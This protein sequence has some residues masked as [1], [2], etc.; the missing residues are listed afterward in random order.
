M[1]ELYIGGVGLARGYINQ[2]ELTRRSFIDNPFY[3]PHQPGHSSRLYKTGD[4]VRWLPDG[5][6]EYLGRTD[7]QIKLRGL[8]IELTEIEN[9]LLQVAGVSEGTVIA[10]KMDNGDSRLLAYIVPQDKSLLQG[11]T[12]VVARGDYLD[13]LRQAL[14]HQLLDYM[15]PDVFVL[16]SE[17]PLSANG[18]LDRKALPVPDMSS[19]Q[20]T[21]V[22]PET[23][24]ERVIHDIW[25][26]H[27]GLNEISI[28]DNFFQLGGHSILVINML[29]S[30]RNKGI[31]LE[32]R[33]I[34]SYPTIYKLSC[35][36]D[37]RVVLKDNSFVTPENLICPGVERI[38]PQMLPLVALE[39]TEI[40]EIVKQVPGGL[41][42]VQD[43]YPLGPLQSG[44]LYHYRLTP[45]SDPYLIPAE[46]TINGNAQLE[47]FLQA[48]Q[49]VMER[50]DTLRT[51]I[52]WEGTSTPVQVVCKQVDLS[53]ERIELDKQRPPFERLFTAANAHTPVIEIN[54]GP[55]IKIFAGAERSS[56][57]YKVLI[58]FHHIVFDHVGLEII[59]GE[60]AAYFNQQQEALTKP[61]QYREFIATLAN[62]ST[63]QESLDFFRE[64]LA[65]IEE[66]T[67]PFGLM[68]VHGNGNNLDIV[69]FDLP[70]SL[71]RSI[72]AISSKLS[73][74]PAAF[75]HLAWAA[76][77]A[78]ACNKKS[79]VFGT[80]MSGRLQGTESMDNVL[81][82]FINT[83]PIRITL[84]DVALK[85]Q[86]EQ[87]NKA[88]IELIQH[89]QTPLT[90]AQKGAGLAA[91]LPLFTSLLNYRHSSGSSVEDNAGDENEGVF[92]YHGGQE[93]T[94]YP[95]SLTVDNLSNRFVLDLQ[96]H[97]EISAKRVVDYMVTTLEKMAAALESDNATTEAVFHNPLLSVLSEDERNLQLYD[98]NAVTREF[99]TNRCIHDLFEEKVS[100][101]PD[102]VALTCNMEALSYAELNEQAN[103]LAHYLSDVKQVSHGDLIGVC[104]GRSLDMVVSLLAILKVGAAYVP[105]DPDYP[106]SRIEYMVQDSGTRLLITS[107]KFVEKYQSLDIDSIDLDDIATREQISVHKR[108]NLVT[109]ES[110]CEDLTYV[111]YTSGSTGKPKGVMVQHKGIINTLYDN[112][113]VF[114][115]NEGTK[116]LHTLTINF[117][118]ASWILWMT[119]LHG[120]TVVIAES[121]SQKSR[122]LSNYA[123]RHDASH[124]M[125]TPSRLAMLNPD[126]V[127]KVSHVIVGGEECPV[128]L[129]KE[130]AG[131]VKLINAYGPTEVSMCSTTGRVYGDEEVISIGKP[132]ANTPMYV[133]STDLQLLPVGVA[134]ELYIGGIGLAKG[135]LGLDNLTKERFIDN[136]FYDTED[137]SSSQKLYK[138]GDL[139]KWL[140]NGSLEF[141]G[142][143]DNQVK[144]RGY[145]I[146]LG[147]IEA[148][149]RS[150]SRV[151]SAV[152]LAKTHI[153][154]TK[155]LVAY[156]TVCQSPSNGNV[157]YATLVELKTHLAQSLPEYMIP[158]DIRVIETMPLTPNGKIDRQVLAQISTT[159]ETRDFVPPETQMEKI[160]CQIWQ[161]LL[162][163]NRVSVTDNFFEIGGHSLSAMKFFTLLWQRHQIDLDVKT[164]FEFPTLQHLANYI[165]VMHS[166]EALVET[167]TA[168]E[169]KME[170][171][172]I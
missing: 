18:K 154:K 150:F 49:F 76:V 74:S 152:V 137:P 112:A 102:A 31:A 33:D 88:L 7:A 134:G 29:G 94:N 22:A 155:Y 159:P 107:G 57:T 84:T 55:L 138:T 156:V 121:L 147:E 63:E 108:H 67:A 146:E 100:L 113:E 168:E 4:V 19:L 161:E 13:G 140:P 148:A 54:K 72:H 37:N 46:F 123:N 118:S 35:Y 1:G 115:V 114:E 32:A 103:Q 167:E 61:K 149:I 131:R 129:A 99:P 109:S 25:A 58:Y 23:T 78:S 5:Q 77:V 91:N 53:F 136:P 30:L 43:I 52:V 68:D 120:G 111:I 82:V 41:N 144:I 11:E 80:V 163:L 97:R 65:D 122:D 20:A 3:D 9:Q 105:L 128:G 59:K 28:H 172:K 2:E 127:P 34:F 153:D 135:Y 139:V 162:G 79:V 73:V 164:I 106:T 81:G 56:E 166:G 125:M 171:F 132:N 126:E 151:S 38:T 21:Y 169:Q 104:L 45:E 64:Q 71:T 15:I 14:A 90:I 27:L 85:V 36:I 124:L 16:L 89:E 157:N 165:D 24:T 117:D 87:V 93:Y 170:N 17:L 62:K 158:H 40:D 48:L 51:I 10:S 110:S 143:I 101:H 86:I 50:H 116:F 66:T 130:W 75:F 83:L 44:I 141:I 96:C 60:I 145:R 8:R 12:H 70:D 95:L 92:E 119:L 6:L 133:L 26:A 98:W 160:M 142:R 42:N 47:L 39:Q 69:Q